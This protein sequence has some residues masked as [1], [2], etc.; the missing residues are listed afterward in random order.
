ME[1]SCLKTIAG[2]HKS[3]VHKIRRKYKAGKG[4]WG[5]PYE[6]KTAAKRCLFVDY[7]KCKDVKHPTDVVDNKAIQMSY[8]RTTFESRLKAKCCELCG[9]E[10]AEY[11]EIHHI[12]KLKDLKGKQPWERM[13][14]AKRRKTMVLCRECHK[15]IH[16]KKKEFL[17]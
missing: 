12:H 2:K 15:T 16:G 4:K 6:T 13:M 5:I 14:L 17:N 7:R 11:Y 1:Y 8:S 10:T 9:T 3:H